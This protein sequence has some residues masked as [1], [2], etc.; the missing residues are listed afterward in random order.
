MPRSHVWH[1]ILSLRCFLDSPPRTVLSD[2]ALEPDEVCSVPGILT[3][4]F[5]SLVS[6]SIQ[7]YSLVITQASA[8]VLE[9]ET[10]SRRVWGS[11]AVSRQQPA[12]R[13]GLECTWDQRVSGGCHGLNSAHLGSV[14]SLYWR[15][16]ALI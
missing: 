9:P 12:C 15:I 16:S 7:G 13:L 8:R 2:P 1:C 10:L 5:Y 6:V 14:S 11:L 4:K 3:L